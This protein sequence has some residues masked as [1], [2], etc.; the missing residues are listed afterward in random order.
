[1]NNLVILSVVLVF[2]FLNPLALVLAHFFKFKNLW[3]WFGSIPGTLHI[4]NA[5][6][7]INI[8]FYN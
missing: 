7:S 2:Q 1:L 5:K 6:D 3:A 4:S 8:E